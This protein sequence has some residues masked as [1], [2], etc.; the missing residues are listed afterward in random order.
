MSDPVEE[1]KAAVGA[2]TDIE[3]AARLGLE[4][5]TIAQWRRRGQVPVRYRDLVKLPGTVQ[6]DRYVRSADRRS[7]YGDGSGRYI[8][9]ACLA[10]TPLHALDFGED[11]SPANVGWAREARI[12][13]V[14]R[15]VLEV[16]T[17]L[18]GKPRCETEEEF[19]RLMS[20]LEQPDTKAHIALALSRGI[21]GEI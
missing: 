13:S 17:I 18:F 4:R 7:I 1:L 10:M 11:L 8:L 19:L 12:L 21:I 9:S 15:V 5:S 20:A 14:A 6:I 2:Q 3:L 16:C